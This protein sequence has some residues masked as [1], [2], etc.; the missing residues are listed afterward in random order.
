[1]PAHNRSTRR[2]AA[3][4]AALLAAS[5]LL[6]ACGEPDQPPVV[7]DP[8]AGSSQPQPDEPGERN[9]HNS[10]PTF[11]PAPYDEDPG[12]S[13][14]HSSSQLADTADQATAD[15]AALTGIDPAQIRVVA[16]EHVTWPDSALGCPEPDGVY[17]AA[18]VDGYRLELDTG[19]HRL[20]YHG[21]DGA[22]P[23]HCDDPADPADTDHGPASGTELAP[24]TG[25]DLA[26]GT[27]GEPDR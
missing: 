16:A 17:T 14:A 8:S 18:L 24:D 21:A 12:S 22:L 13:N 19:E 23:F 1:M 20:H 5:L 26:P 6:A 11:D 9:D 10:A 27:S 25:D 4:L 3:T 15:A 2:S 7:G